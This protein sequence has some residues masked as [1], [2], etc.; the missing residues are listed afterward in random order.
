MRTGDDEPTIE[1]LDGQIVLRAVFELVRTLRAQGY[2]IA[3]VG[4]E[5][6]ITP[7]V[8][9]NVWAILDSNWVSV[10]AVLEELDET[11]PQD[12]R[13]VLTARQTIH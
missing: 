3:I 5:V 6:R 9:E 2:T 4:D 13:I 12:T 7:T 11:E 1:L 10:E 8:H